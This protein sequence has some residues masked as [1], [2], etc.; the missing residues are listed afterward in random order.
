METSEEPQAIVRCNW[1]AN[2]CPKEVDYHDKEWGVAVLDDSKLFEFL[3][4]EGAQ[5][6][7]SWR[8][9]LLKRDGYRRAFANFNPTK[10]ARFGEA[11][12]SKLLEDP[13]IVRNRLKV[14]SAVSNA[15]AFLEI[16]A[17]FGSFSAYLWGFVSGQPIQNR[18]KNKAQVPV[19]TP[20]SDA[21]SKN[22]KKRGFRF[23]G[24]TICYSY[25]QAM[26]LTNDHTTDC[27]RWKPLSKTARTN[28]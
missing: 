9:V 16:Q 7:L 1:S 25:M 8:T 4:L 3:L 11:K 26:G 2:G 19:T 21:L 6:G 5:A 24:S 14:N 12:I 27:F 13:S 20:V 17:E 28:G 23:V 18:F 22:L 15:R 10:V